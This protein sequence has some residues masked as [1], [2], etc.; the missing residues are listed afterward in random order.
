MYW[1]RRQFCRIP[2][3]SQHPGSTV[4]KVPPSFQ[5][6]DGSAPPATRLDD[7]IFTSSEEGLPTTAATAAPSDKGGGNTDSDITKAL[8]KLESISSNDNEE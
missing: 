6:E 7:G 4:P 5:R 8:E 2:R 3:E 1:L